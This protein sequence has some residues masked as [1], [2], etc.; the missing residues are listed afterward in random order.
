MVPLDEFSTLLSEADL[1]RVILELLVL[2]ISDYV[3]RDLI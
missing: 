3:I 1:I 2:F